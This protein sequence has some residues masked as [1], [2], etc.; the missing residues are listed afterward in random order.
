MS[1]IWSIEEYEEYRKDKNKKNKKPKYNNK[2]FYYNGN[3][4]DSTKEA[5]YAMQLDLRVKAK[6]IVKWERQVPIERP[7]IINY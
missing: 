6:E 2:R 3:W 7:S 4:Y 5:K 1:N